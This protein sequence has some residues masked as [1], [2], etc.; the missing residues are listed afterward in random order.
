MIDMLRGADLQ[1]C[2]K[3]VKK[4]KPLWVA[5]VIR[6]AGLARKTPVAP[7][8]ALGWR[9]EAENVFASNLKR[10]GP[11]PRPRFISL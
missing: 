5:F 11:W 3:A 10:S 7:L 9:L 1:L 4:L 8:E 2:R 6:F